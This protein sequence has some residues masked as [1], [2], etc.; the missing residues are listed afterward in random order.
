MF[1][2]VQ[3]LVMI[4]IQDQDQDLHHQGVIHIS[5]PLLSP[6]RFFLFAFPFASIQGLSVKGEGLRVMHVQCEPFA[7]MHRSSAGH[8]QDALTTQGANEKAAV[9]KMGMVDVQV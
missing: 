3:E 9:Q 7:A 8:F 6:S 2:V 1:L 4:D 5:L